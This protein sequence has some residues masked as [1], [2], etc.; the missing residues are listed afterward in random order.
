MND[1][2]LSRSLRLIK[3]R[4]LNLIAATTELIEKDIAGR[5][6]LSEALDVTIRESWPPDLY[7]PRAMQFASHNSVMYQSRAGHFGIC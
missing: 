4:R 7:G 6:F 3:S 5:D 1:A 2:S